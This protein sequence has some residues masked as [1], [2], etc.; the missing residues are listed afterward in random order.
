MNVIDCYFFAGAAGFSSV[1]CRLVHAFDLGVGTQLGDQ[2]G[3]RLA[4]HKI[5]DLRLH[6]FEF[7]RLVCALVFDLDDMPAELGLHRL[8]N[9]SL[10]QFEGGFGEFRHHLLLGEVAEIAAIGLSGRVF[11]DFAGHLGEVLTLLQPDDH[12]LD[13]VLGFLAGLVVA[14]RRAEQDVA[15][16]HF[17]LFA[18]LLDGFVIDLVHRLVG[19]RFL[20][21]RLQQPF[22]EQLLAGEFELAFE[23]GPNRRT[24]Y[25]RAAFD[26]RIMSATNC[27]R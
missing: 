10:V 1:F 6:L 5:L 3:L 26:T 18:D 16:M 20:A 27:T 11:G 9:L 15:G 24:S 23:V 21:D 22:H 7:R 13:L 14:G 12:R 25:P 8:R 17:L 19:E 2:L 4:H